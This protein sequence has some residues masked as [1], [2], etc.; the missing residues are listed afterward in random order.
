MTNGYHNSLFVKW[1]ETG[2]A[3]PVQYGPE[4]LLLFT[5][6]A[7]WKFWDSIE[8]QAYNCIWI[9]IAWLIIHCF[10]W[11]LSWISWLITTLFLVSPSRLKSSISSHSKPR[12]SPRTRFL[13]YHLQ[14]KC[15]LLAGK[16][17]WGYK[18]KHCRVIS[19]NFLFSKVCWRRP[20]MFCLYTSSKLSHP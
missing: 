4:I 20:A 16:F 15:R 18:A 8:D 19:T 2:P 13:I 6:S 5:N 9:I 11:F 17:T 10:T 3:M 12:T 7:F 1:A 14:G